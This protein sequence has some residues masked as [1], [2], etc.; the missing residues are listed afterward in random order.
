MKKR[1]IVV[2][3]LSIIIVGI[4]IALVFGMRSVRI[5]DAFISGKYTY[6]D[7]SIEIEADE[8]NEVLNRPIITIRFINNSYG[9]NNEEYS[10]LLYADPGTWFSETFYISDWNEKLVGAP[11]TAKMIFM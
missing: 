11:F 5:Y 1:I 7:D 3:V 9:M 6:K 8:N 10:Y 4:A 2:A